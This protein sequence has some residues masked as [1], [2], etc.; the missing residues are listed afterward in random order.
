[1]IY[2]KQQIQIFSKMLNNLFKKVLNSF[3]SKLMILLLISW[4]CCLSVLSQISN[5]Q[6]G[7][8]L[9]SIHVV[10]MYIRCLYL[11]GPMTI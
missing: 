6:K 8:L 11:L 10:N 1:M 5:Q 3:F 7:Q 9:T 4:L 2:C